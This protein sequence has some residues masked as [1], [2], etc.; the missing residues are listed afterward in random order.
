MLLLE[1]LKV[2]V[3]DVV[4]HIIKDVVVDDACVDVVLYFST[5]I[6]C[7]VDLFLNILLRMLLLVVCY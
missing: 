4:E 5:C 3:T 1:L 6:C 7:G 2:V